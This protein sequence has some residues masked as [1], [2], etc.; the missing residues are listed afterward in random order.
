MTVAILALMTTVGVLTGLS[1]YTADHLIRTAEERELKAL[2]SE[3]TNRVN[4][5]ERM[6]AALAGS[7]SQLKGVTTRF[8]RRERE[9][10]AERMVPLYDFL[11]E[12]YQIEQLHFHTPEA[13]SFLRA[14]KP[15]KFGDD[16]SGFRKT[17]VQAN[18]FQEEITGLERGIAG[19]GIRGVVPVY[20]QGQHLGSVEIGLS[21][22]EDYFQA[23]AEEIELE[24]FEM[25][26]HLAEGGAGKAVGGADSLSLHASTLEGAGDSSRL[27]PERDQLEH[28]FASGED[29]GAF[30]HNDDLATPSAVYAA[31]LLDYEGKKI[32]VVEVARSRSEYAA[33]LAET[34]WLFIGVGA[35]VLVIGVLASLL[36]AR[37]ISRPLKATIDQM[38]VAANGDLTARMSEDGMTEIAELGKG[39]NRL[40]ASLSDLVGD[41][42]NA[43]DDLVASSEQMIAVTRTTKANVDDQQ[44]DTEQVSTAMEQM[45]TTV[46]HVAEHAASTAELARSA[47]ERAREGREVVESTVAAIRELAASVESAGA[48]MDQLGT[49][50][51]SIRSVLDVIQD[52]AEQTNLLALNAAI[53]AARAG[54]AGRGFAVVADEVRNL[55]ARTQ[56]STQEIQQVIERVQGGAR[57]ANEAMNANREQTND[58]VEKAENAGKAL[59]AITES[60]YEVV[61]RADQIASSTEEQNA[62]SAEVVQS[63][64]RIHDRAHETAEA[65]Q[66]TSDAGGRLES[67]STR[68]HEHVSRFRYGRE[69]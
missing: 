54:E 34:Q 36:I 8:E 28:A 37:S 7:L 14:H 66:Q 22:G 45:S 26:L 32:G 11:H 27:L 3:I 51:E 19:L 42:A 43:T 13:R 65:A 30:A 23:I 4:A 60:V 1:L 9:A 41:V 47:D 53:E 25:S 68:L 10:M 17:V 24:G 67:L 20:E 40:A 38:E 59:N 48:T 31:P 12:H 5:R 52:V 16:L 46:G 18:R 64:T 49:E 35:F 44:S 58:A 21:F 56:E 33:I 15:E 63:I 61:D 55:A 39:F 6:A 2:H 62:A 57:E 29:Q 50:T 69:G